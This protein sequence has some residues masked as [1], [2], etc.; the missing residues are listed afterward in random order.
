MADYLAILPLLIFKEISEEKIYLL[1]IMIVI[2]N[3]TG[4]EI[5]PGN[6]MYA[7]AKLLEIII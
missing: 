6:I 4:E 5:M 1:Y 2:F 7:N 3:Y